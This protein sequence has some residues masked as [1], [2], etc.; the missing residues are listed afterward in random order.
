MMVGKRI[1]DEAS[2]NEMFVKMLDLVQ[3]I[4][5]HTENF[6]ADQLNVWGFEVRA[7]QS[8]PDHP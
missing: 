6:I 8:V 1:D 2:V 7:P 3:K 5:E 4:T